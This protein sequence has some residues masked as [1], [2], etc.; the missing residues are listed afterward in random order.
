[1]SSHLVGTSCVLAGLDQGDGGDLGQPGPLRGPLGLGD[2]PTLDLGVAEL[3]PGLVGPA[4]LGGG[5]VVAPPGAP[6]RPSER[7][8]LDAGRVDAVAI[9]DEHAAEYI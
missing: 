6:K 4:P 7:L 5:V 1:C 3:L 8:P 2:H 9:P